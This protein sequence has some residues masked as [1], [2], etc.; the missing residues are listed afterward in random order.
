V[1][2]VFILLVIP[3]LLLADLEM[4]DIPWPGGGSNKHNFCPQEKP[5]YPRHNGKIANKVMDTL[6]SPEFFTHAVGALSG[7]VKV[8]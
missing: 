2:L 6:N 1:V 3:L 8:R 7:A 5:L 4:P